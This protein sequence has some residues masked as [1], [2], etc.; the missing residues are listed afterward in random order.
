M[1][2]GMG[3]CFMMSFEEGDAV[4]ARHLNIQRH[5]VGTQFQD[6]VPGG[7]RVRR[8]ADNFDVRKRRQTDGDDLP[9]QRGVIDDQKTNG[10]RCS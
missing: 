2:T 3:R 1:I 7:V 9:R 10:C 5:H 8:C 6:F 4:H